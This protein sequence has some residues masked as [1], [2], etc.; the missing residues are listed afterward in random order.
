M[1]DLETLGNQDE[2]HHIELLYIQL[3]EMSEV[4]ETFVGEDEDFS[5]LQHR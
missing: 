5:K 1:I 4:E 2:S 3:G